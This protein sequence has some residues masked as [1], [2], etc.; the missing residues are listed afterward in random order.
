MLHNNIWLHSF[1]S[2]DH[3]FLIT[4]VSNDLLFIE[5]GGLEVFED[6]PENILVTT[7]EVI[8]VSQTDLWNNNLPLHSVNVDL[9]ID[10]LRDE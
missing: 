7:T 5:V 2:D 6:K 3:S 4:H 8:L 1:I 10:E 9:L